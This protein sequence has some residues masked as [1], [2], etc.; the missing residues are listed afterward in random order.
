MTSEAPEVKVEAGR[1]SGEGKAERI[2]EAGKRREA[3]FGV[4]GTSGELLVCL[5]GCLL[6]LPGPGRALP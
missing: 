1:S 5:V 6:N 4:R 2:E 3:G